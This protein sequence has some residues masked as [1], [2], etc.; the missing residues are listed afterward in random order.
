MRLSQQNRQYGDKMEKRKKETA[1][2]LSSYISDRCLD[3][4]C[5]KA[6][7]LVEIAEQL[8]QSAPVTLDL[9]SNCEHSHCPAQGF[10]C[11]TGTEK[12]SPQN[13]D[14]LLLTAEQKTT[15]CIAEDLEKGTFPFDKISV[16]TVGS[17]GHGSPA[18]TKYHNCLVKILDDPRTSEYFVS[19]HKSDFK[20]EKLHFMPLGLGLNGELKMGLTREKVAE[21]LAEAGERYSAL[22]TQ[23]KCAQLD[24]FT[25]NFG[26]GNPSKKEHRRDVEQEMQRLS[27]VPL[28]NNYKKTNVSVLH[29]YVDSVFVVSPQGTLRLLET[30]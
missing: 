9:F 29:Q 25:I 4:T 19:Q 15:C 28:I 10:D 27:D 1:K 13:K 8:Q 5:Y 16:V 22:C 7:A 11:K 14:I 23:K 17:D 12:L 30:L 2:K 18:G 6:K 24:L 26:T 21:V 20:H 3:I